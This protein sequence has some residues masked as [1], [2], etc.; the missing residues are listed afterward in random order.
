[1]RTKKKEFCFFFLELKKIQ[2]S[3]LI[4]IKIFSNP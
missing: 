3:K 4:R 2:L 1:M